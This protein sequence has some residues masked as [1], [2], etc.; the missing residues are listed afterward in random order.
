MKKSIFIV[1]VLFLITSISAVNIIQVRSIPLRQDSNKFIKC[2][3]SFFV[4][5]DDLVF[6]LDKK[7]SNIKIFNLDGR[8]IQTFG[9]KGMGPGELIMPF[10]SAYKSP[11]VVFMDFGRRSCFIYKRSPTKILELYDR[12]IE[13][14]AIYGYQIMNDEEI[15]ITGDKR[16]RKGKLFSLSV[17]NHKSRKY[18]YLLPLEVS[19]GEAS[20]KEWL[21]KDQEKY[22]PIGSNLFSDWWCDYVYHA[23]TADLKIMKLNR[24]SGKI[25]YFGKKTANYIQPRVTAVLEKTFRE[26]KNHQYFMLTNGMSYIRCLFTMNSGHVGVVYTGAALGDGKIRVM[27]Q[28]YENS[29]EFVKE[30]ELLKARA[31][32]YNELYLYFRKDKNLFYIL[33]TETTKDFDQLYRLYEY[34]ISQ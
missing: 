14:G 23:W 33:D 9:R 27:L 26:R 20:V 17:Y 18:D 10:S 1:A 29:G 12:F 3:G 13:L 34:R 7:D 4:T 16:N 22:G 6:I 8:M 21:E 28:L 5:E 19:Y 2:P 32:H 24:K 11:W 15:L 30:A 31:S 25:N